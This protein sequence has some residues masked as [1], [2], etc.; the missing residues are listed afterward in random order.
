M[1]HLDNATSL[2][3]KIQDILG[4]INIKM[5]AKIKNVLLGNK[6]KNQ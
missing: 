5:A 4:Y 1:V 3:L 2:A 6:R